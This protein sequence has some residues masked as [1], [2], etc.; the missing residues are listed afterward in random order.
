MTLI[1]LELQPTNNASRRKAGE[2][3][4]IQKGQTLTP[5]GINRRNER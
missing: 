5:D 4:L 2:A 3:Y 1:S